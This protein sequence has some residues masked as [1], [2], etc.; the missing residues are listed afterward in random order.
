LLDQPVVDIEIECLVTEIPES[1]RV[2]VADLGIGDSLHL[3]DITLPEG[4]TAEGSADLVL[5]TVRAPTAAEE[6]EVAA[7]AEGEGGT[8]PEVI[9]RK[10]KEEP[11]EGKE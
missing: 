1:I 4:V 6:E 9:A 5:C 10:E 3:S 11:G 2:S 8:E 7:E